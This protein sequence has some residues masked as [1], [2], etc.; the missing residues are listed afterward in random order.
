MKLRAVHA[1]G[2]AIVIALGLALGANAADTGTP[3]DV[4][5][6]ERAE[7]NRKGLRPA[8]DG[9]SGVH[10]TRSKRTFITAAGTKPAATATPSGGPGLFE[11]LFGE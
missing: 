2:L 3:G 10:R 4:A 6:Q 7:Q 1:P 5:L 8:H 11:R 9:K